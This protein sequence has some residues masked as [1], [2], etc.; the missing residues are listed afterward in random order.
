MLETEMNL[1]IKK[2]ER[3]IKLKGI[4]IIIIIYLF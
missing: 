3:N 4:I 1:I 2:I